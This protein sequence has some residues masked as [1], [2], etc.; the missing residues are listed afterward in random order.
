MGGSRSRH[1]QSVALCGAVFLFCLSIYVLTSPGR[2]DSIDGQYRFD[3]SASLVA[4]G[5]PE[6]RDP[7][8]APNG[9]VGPD[10]KRYFGWGP[11]PSFLALP[12]VIVGSVAGDSPG[13]LSR[14]LFSLLNAIVVS[15]TVAVLCL[16]FT[17]LGFAARTSA[18]AALSIGFG[19]L[20]WIGATTVL[21]QGQHTLFAL[22][23]VLLAWTS[24]K[25]RSPALAFAG[26][27]AA[28][29]LTLYQ[30][31]YAILLP[32]L[33]LSTLKGPAEG[34]L[35]RPL[36]ENLNRF[37]CFGL[38]SALV[39]MTAMLYNF[40]RFGGVLF[41]PRENLGTHPPIEGN[42]LVGV[43]TL[44][45][46]P[47]KGLLL[48]CPLVVMF[49]LGFGPL[50]RRERWLG[51]AVLGASVVH[52]SFVGSLTIFHGDWCWGPRYLIVLMPLL[53]LGFPF[54]L[55]NASSGMKRFAAALVCF[56]V[57]SNLLGLSLVHERFFHEKGLA[58]YFWKDDPGF[59]WRES[60]Y[61]HRVGEIAATIRE[62]IPPEAKT[63][64]NSPYPGLLTYVF[65][66]GGPPQVD[67]PWIRRYRIFYRPR[68]WPLWLAAEKENWARGQGFPAFWWLVGSL[69][70]MGAGGAWMIR[71][72]VRR[73]ERGDAI[74]PPISAT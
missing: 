20:L 32:L 71:S 42:P 57:F 36:R 72:A 74:A 46:S 13:E 1:S 44:L 19:S 35:P 15:G 33:A 11:A 64:T 6:L 18:V 48:F 23:G 14:F 68:P 28:G 41:D 65:V 43:P 16:F 45:V 63:F 49:L 9:V 59:Y 58:I 52:L 27:M 60:N 12:L 40:N 5:L 39:V 53:A 26:G 51:I 70:T 38:G 47:G 37:V 34:W 24:A 55:M 31:T 73:A 29:I 54:A 67:A 30:M 4:T 10:G 61:F 21:E 2:I 50:L 3:I 22:L 7:F 8:L 69:V 66:R 62:G 56:G 17:D 25:R